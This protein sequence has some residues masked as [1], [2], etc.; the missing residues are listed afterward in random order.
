M[1]PRMKSMVWNIR[2]QRYPISTE[3]EKRIKKI[4]DSVR[5]LWDNFKYFNI[6]NIGVPEGEEKEYE[7][8][9]LI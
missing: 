1:K 6:H 9:N 5:S 8:R 7:I 2:K 3:E 4:K